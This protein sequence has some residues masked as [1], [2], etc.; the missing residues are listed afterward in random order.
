MMKEKQNE[1][2][3]DET[4]EFA[5]RTHSEAMKLISVSSDSESGWYFF[6]CGCSG[7][8]GRPAMLGWTE[9]GIERSL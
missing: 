7:I 8:K 1:S 2:G 3:H 4:V 5:A 6:I 9:T